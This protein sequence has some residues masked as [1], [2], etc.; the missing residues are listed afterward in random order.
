MNKLRFYL[1]VA[2]AGIG[3]SFVLG[4]AV[5]RPSNMARNP[6]GGVA[7]LPGKNAYIVNYA[8]GSGVDQVVTNTAGVFGGASVTTSTVV[9]TGFTSVTAAGAAYYTTS[10]GLTGMWLKAAGGPSPNQIT[11]TQ[12][13][14][15]S[16]SDSTPVAA[17]SLS[18]VSY[19]ATGTGQ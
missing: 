17:S 9:D 18:A 5:Q 19:W 13:K 8:P 3:A 12:T 16:S 10:P 6:G 14:P 2:L 15:T 4:A 7:Y 11:I 1:S